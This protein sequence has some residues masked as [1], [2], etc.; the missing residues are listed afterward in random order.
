MKKLFLKVIT[1]LIISAAFV[2]PLFAQD[3]NDAEAYTLAYFKRL[4]KTQEKLTYM[5][6]KSS[7]A[8]V[9]TE[10]IKGD[11]SGTLF[12][13][14][15]IKGMGAVV[16]LRYTNYCDEEGWI[17]D[18]EIITSSNMAQNGTFSGTIK[19]S[20][21]SPA[22]VFYDNVVMKKGLPAEGYYLAKFEQQPSFKIDYTL[23]LKSLEIE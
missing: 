11:I 14:V 23:Y 6:K 3:Q 10:T 13:T 5:R 20:G 1:I 21:I 15:K 8:K 9:G 19:I 2:H 22:E 16:T 4:N 18:G 7:L 12:Y 17:F